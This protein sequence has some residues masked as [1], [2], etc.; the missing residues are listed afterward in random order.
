MLMLALTTPLGGSLV[1]L[2]DASAAGG[3]GTNAL[4][5]AATPPGEDARDVARAEDVP[6][7]ASA[8]ITL[9]HSRMLVDAEM[10]RRDGSWRNVRL[11]VDTG[12]PDLFLSESLARDLEL[13][14]SHSPEEL[15]DG[16]LE[17]PPPTG[18]RLGGMA[19]DLEGVQ[20]W[21]VF[22][23]E[24]LFSTMHN[25]ANLP[26]TVLHRYQVVFDYPRRE[27]TIAQPGSLRPRGIAAPA[28]IQPRT[29]IVQLGAVVAGDTLSFALDNGASYSFTSAKVLDRLANRHPDW[30]TCT[31]A[32]GAANIWG[33]WPQEESWRVLRVPEIRWGPVTL[34][35][36]GLVG[37]GEIFGPGFDLGAWYSKKTA[38][39]VDGFLGPNAF[40]GFRVEI[41]YADST[42]YFEE[43]PTPPPPD[44][45][46]VGL[47]LRPEVDG[48][49]TVLGV[50]ELDGA[51]GVPGVE[52]GDR[53][54]RVDGLDTQGATMGTVVD[55]L[56]GDPGD[57]HL[58]VL[59]RDGR[60]STVEAVVHRFLALSPP[61]IP[62]NR[63]GGP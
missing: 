4:P 25:D 31:G 23:P 27:L 19:L 57:V 55:A 42:V 32:L 18:L 7:Q 20:T 60:R 48:G 34:P 9:D 50:A 30:H 3:R 12:N 45:D 14:L 54:I 51:P 29:G 10:R 17:V 44:M 5:S 13:D 40:M 1:R 15:V 6:R 47:T 24:W 33:W 16:R 62:L 28:L 22:E 49:Y 56:R 11:W 53:L 38:Q 36:V 21:V 39:P 58:L 2:P 37:L 35:Q 43:G 41:D 59:E 8:G 46:L 52:R 26:A 63:D 61:P